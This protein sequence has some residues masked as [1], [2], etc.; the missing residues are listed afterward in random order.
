MTRLNTRTDAVSAD[1]PASIDPDV[2]CLDAFQRELDYVH[3]TLRRLGAAPCDIEDLAQEV[4]LVL[5]G[6]WARCDQTRRLRPYLFGI[7]FRISSAHRRRHRREVPLRGIEAAVDLTAD[8]DDAMQSKQARR[9]ILAALDRVPLARRAV[10][11]MHD[12]DDVPV[13]EIASI[14]GIPLFTTYSRLRKA[15]REL[16][17]AMRRLLTRTRGEVLA[18]TLPIRR[19]AGGPTSRAHTRQW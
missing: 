15:R 12:L 4:F 3:A 19:H 13:A 9:L 11:L 2:A 8:L 18:H 17:S 14:L 10:L 5:R 7:A 1:A 16:A 6:A